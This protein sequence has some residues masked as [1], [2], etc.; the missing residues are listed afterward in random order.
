MKE[1]SFFVSK[2]ASYG[3]LEAIIREVGSTGDD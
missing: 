1:I 2:G 3:K